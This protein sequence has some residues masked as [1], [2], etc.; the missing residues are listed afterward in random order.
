MWIA[1]E[2]I[3]AIE[4]LECEEPY[5]EGGQE[6]ADGGA[7]MAGGCVAEEEA[8]EVSKVSEEGGQKHYGTLDIPRAV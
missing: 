5:Q 3:S 6:R 8:R 4:L 1:L 2:R 7:L